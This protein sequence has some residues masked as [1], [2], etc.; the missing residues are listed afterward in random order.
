MLGTTNHKMLN[1]ENTYANYVP[2]IPLWAISDYYDKNKRLMI[3]ARKDP[4]IQ[5]ITSQ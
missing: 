5:E 1:Y 2:M 3:A 4:Q